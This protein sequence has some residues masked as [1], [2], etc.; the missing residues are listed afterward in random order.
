MIFFDVNLKKAFVCFCLANWFHNFSLLLK[1]FSSCCV[2]PLISSFH[3]PIKI[4]L[5]PKKKLNWCESCTK[6]CIHFY[7]SLWKIYYKATFY[8]HYR[9]LLYE[10]YK[11]F[12]GKYQYFSY[13]RFKK[14]SWKKFR[15]S[16]EKSK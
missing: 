14:I 2:F 10:E 3:F 11:K 12:S 13:S 8:Y 6:W 4:F 5:P 7:K 16:H 15:H 9:N 1:L